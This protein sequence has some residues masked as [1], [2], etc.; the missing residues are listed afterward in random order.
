MRVVRKRYSASQQ[1][2]LLEQW[3]KS[4]ESAER[5]AARLG[6]K[7]S[8]LSRWQKEAK[9]A[10][11]NASGLARHVGVDA[12]TEKASMFARVQVVDAPERAASMVEVV[13]RAG[14]VVRIHGDV[15]PR[16]LASVLGAV[17]RC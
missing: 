7:P 17:G 9:G 4:G 10:R 6:V 15:D 2:A 1:R 16:V 5:F 3:S 14:H 12:F 8:T 13:T 11:R